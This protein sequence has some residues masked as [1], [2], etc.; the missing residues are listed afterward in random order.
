MLFFEWKKYLSKKTYFFFISTRRVLRGEEREG[1]KKKTKT[2]NTP[3]Q[4][5]KPIGFMAPDNLCLSERALLLQRLFC[6]RLVET[7]RLCGKKQSLRYDAHA[8]ISSKTELL[9]KSRRKYL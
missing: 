2:V 8:Y 3:L 6:C 4:M 7:N 9:S 1:I 5:I